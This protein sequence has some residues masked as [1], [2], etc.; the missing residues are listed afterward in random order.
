MV[1]KYNKVEQR[2]NMNVECG[3]NIDMVEVEPTREKVKRI[4]AVEPVMK[5]KGLFRRLWNGMVGPDGF[6]RI[7]LYVIQDILVPSIKSM[8]A[9]SIKSSVD[10]A[11]NIQRTPVSYGPKTQKTDYGSRFQSVQTTGPVVASVKVPYQVDEYIIGERQEAIEV[12]SY[13]ND[14]AAT[15]GSVAVAEYYDML[16]VAPKFTD[17][18]YGW[19]KHRMLK[20]S[21]TMLRNGEGYVIK[22]PPMEVL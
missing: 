20:A 4:V 8:I 6:H 2:D 1:V 18:N 11:F 22:F 13:L 5:K 15:Y 9:D 19:D 10:M 16:G 17:N 3:D 14:M 21:I 7:R 12:L